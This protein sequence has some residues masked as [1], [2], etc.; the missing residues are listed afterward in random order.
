MKLPM[1][2]KLVTILVVFAV[3]LSG[4]AW[5]INDE[6]KERVEFAT[7]AH[8][9]VHYRDN[10]SGGARFY[11]LGGMDWD[12]LIWL[13]SMPA[14]ELE[15][16]G[17]PAN[18]MDDLNNFLVTLNSNVRFALVFYEF[19]DAYGHYALEENEWLY[20][21]NG[22]FVNNAGLLDGT[23]PW[24][25]YIIYT[26]DEDTGNTIFRHGLFSVRDI[27]VSN[28]GGNGDNNGGGNGNIDTNPPAGSNV[29]TEGGTT[30]TQ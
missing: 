13:E 6:L 18:L 12:T 27:G 5:A 22:T 17:I 23:Q 19:T 3:M 10:F 8:Y 7:G 28:G 21:R 30:V 1:S 26:T 14:E 9:N 16:W 20:T 24:E 4:L 25:F 29:T 2:V 15:A 11:D